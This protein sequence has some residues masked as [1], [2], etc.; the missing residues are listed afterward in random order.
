M[1]KSILCPLCGSENPIS[2]THCQKCG[3]EINSQQM[4]TGKS[5]DWLN[6]LRTTSDQGLNLDAN[7]HLIDNNPLEEDTQSDSPDWLNRIR[8]RKEIDDEFSKLTEQIS[9]QEEIRNEP[10]Q[11]EN[12]IESFRNQAKNNKNQDQESSELIS[13][14]RDDDI[15]NS[16]EIISDNNDIILNNG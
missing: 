10:D 4:N 2:E 11:T 1:T 14:F 8:D 16:F 6:E 7:D 12:L 3:F 13:N 5:S 9:Q 15:D